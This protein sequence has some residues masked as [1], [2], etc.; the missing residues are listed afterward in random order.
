MLNTSLRETPADWVST[1][2]S[3]MWLVAVMSPLLKWLVL[4]K[5]TAS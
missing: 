5:A 2:M 1:R 4:M 3:S